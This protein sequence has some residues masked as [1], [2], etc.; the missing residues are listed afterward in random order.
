ME[1]SICNRIDGTVADMKKGTATTSVRL[2]TNLG[3]VTLVITSSSVEELALTV[4]D[5]VGAL[6]REV[7]V[8][9][10]TGSGAISTGNRFSGRILDI[11][12]G[13]VTVELALDLGKEQRIVAV[14]ARTAAEEMGLGLG[15]SVTACVREGD[16]ILDKGGALSIRNRLAGTISN[17]RPGTV[18]TEVS[19]DTSNGSLQALLARSAAD[20]MGL[21]VGQRVITL[22]RE[23]DFM[24]QR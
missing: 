9:L 22:V 4:D 23:R 20:E 6:F 11:K 18:T 19:L 3:E 8:M 13:G 10:M 14:V 7:D 5:R 15:Q 24:I 1:I 17:L 16:L 21:A 12:R 2:K